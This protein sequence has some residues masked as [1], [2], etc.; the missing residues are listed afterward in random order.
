MKTAIIG[1]RGIVAADSQSTFYL[2]I[3]HNKQSL[4][5]LN[6]CVVYYRNNGCYMSAPMVICYTMNGAY[7]AEI[8]RKND[9]ERPTENRVQ[10]NWHSA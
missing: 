4:Y 7:S 1:S 5:A 8:E 3:L 9:Y 6:L 10:R 2:S